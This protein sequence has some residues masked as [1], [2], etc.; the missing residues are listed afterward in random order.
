MLDIFEN[1]F[2]IYSMKYTLL[3][4]KNYKLKLCLIIEI[5]NSENIHNFIYN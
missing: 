2:K 3:Y 1:N 4:T 5:R